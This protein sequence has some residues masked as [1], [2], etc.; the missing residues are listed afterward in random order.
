MNELSIGKRQ[1]IFIGWNDPNYSRSSVLL[2]YNSSGMPKLFRKIPLGLKNQIKEIRRLGKESN[3]DSIIVVM[4]P[5]HKLAILARALTKSKIVL[6]AGWPLTDGVLSRG[7]SPRNF[8]KLAYVFALD[9]LAFHSAHLVLLETK[10][11]KARVA[12][13][14]LKRKSQIERSFTGYDECCVTET[15]S[16]SPIISEIKLIIKSKEPKLV[17]LFRGKINPE[18]GFENILGASR[19]LD[20]DFLILLATGVP[21][22]VSELS[23]NC[24]LIPMLDKSEMSE[25]YKISDITLGQLSNHPRLKYT[26]PHKAFE[27]GYF[28]MCYLSAKSEGLQEWITPEHAFQIESVSPKTIATSLRILTNR[29]IRE[30]YSS[31][32]LAQYNYLASQNAINEEFEDIIFRRFSQIS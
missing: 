25:L 7:V 19:L 13:I 22:V 17:V 32:L 30:K 3:C 16:K 2:N 5:C 1:C 18:S 11:Q 8:F 9:F 28:G 20:N 26:I 24:I 29:S 14:F 4:S 31:S 15:Q 21:G 23:S 6:D 27:S 12:R 10:I